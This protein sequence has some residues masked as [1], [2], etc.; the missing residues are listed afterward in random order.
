MPPSKK[1][2]GDWPKHV[3]VKYVLLLNLMNIHEA[4]LCPCTQ[5]NAWRYR[6]R[7]S[8]GSQRSQNRKESNHREARHL[9]MVVRE[10]GEAGM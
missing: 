8:F 3:K 6:E 10:E 4:L 2:R 5:L 1:Q 9:G 7:C